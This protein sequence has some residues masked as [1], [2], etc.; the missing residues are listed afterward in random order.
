VLPWGVA[1]ARELNQGVPGRAFS[2]SQEMFVSLVASNYLF[3]WKVEKAISAA[4]DWLARF[5]QLPASGVMQRNV[6]QGGISSLLTAATQVLAPPSPPPA[7]PTVSS[8]FPD[9]FEFQATAGVNSPSRVAASNLR[10]K[11]EPGKEFGYIAIKSFTTPSSGDLTNDLLAEF[12]NLLTLL[13]PNA[14]D[15]LIVD[16]RGNPG[17]DIAAAEGMLQ[18]LT[19]K[20][21]VPLNFHLANTS[22]VLEILKST[23]DSS[24]LGPWAADGNGTPL[25]AGAPLTSGQPL[26]ILT[27]QIGQIYQGPV[28]LLVDA[29]TYSAADMFAAGFSDH[30]IGKIIGPDPNTGGG[31]ASRWSHSQLLTLPANNPGLKAL[32]QSADMGLAFLR[33]TRIGPNDGVAIEDLGVKID[34]AFPRTLFDLLSSAGAPVESTLI[35]SACETLADMPVHRIEVTR[36]PGAQQIGLKATNV[37]SADFLLEQDMEHPVQPTQLKD[38]PQSIDIPLRLDGLVPSQMVV[39]GFSSGTLVARSRLVLVQPAQLPRNRH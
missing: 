6:M 22:A 17:G 26:T 11:S 10:S 37:D 21:I 3:N 9:V 33:C 34:I 19:P 15:G 5:V 13:Q 24:D 16:I 38:G 32:P 31:G 1:Q 23:G 4:A 18:M 39:R 7:T 14:P 20:T 29:L 27:N 36:A 12:R 35:S 28:V 25:P 8:R 2:I 30:G